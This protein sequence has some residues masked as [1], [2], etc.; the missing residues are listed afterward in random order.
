[1]SLSFIIRPLL[2]AA[3]LAS[4]RVGSDFDLETVMQRGHWHNTTRGRPYLWAPPAPMLV[5]A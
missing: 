3:R 1:M 2:M 4:K 5:P